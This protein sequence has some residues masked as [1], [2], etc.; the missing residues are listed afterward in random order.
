MTCS[1]LNTEKQRPQAWPA[2]SDL[3]TPSDYYQLIFGRLCEK[4]T[5]CFSFLQRSCKFLIISVLLVTW[6]EQI[7]DQGSENGMS[8][9][10]LSSAKNF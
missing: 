1:A 5:F 4:L 2:H 7:I 10:T 8:G 6:L 3:S 9:F